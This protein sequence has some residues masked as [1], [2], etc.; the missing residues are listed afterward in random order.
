MTG[1]SLEKC[2]S[3]KTVLVTGHTGFKGS[4]LCIWLHMLGAKV[5][6]ISDR[7]PT[8]PSNFEASNIG[9][10]VEDRRINLIN[11]EELEDAVKEA[12]PDFVFHLA[13]QAL[14]KQSYQDPIETLQTNIMGTANLLESLRKIKNSCVAVM[15]TSD[16]CY[17]NVEW[18]WGYRENDR[19][20]GKD[21]YSASKGGAELVIRTYFESFLKNTPVRL[22]IARAGNVIGGGDWAPD[23]LVPD[24]I[25]AWSE[26]EI[27]EI[28][29]PATTRPWQLVLEPLGGYLC[30]AVSLFKNRELSG[31][32]FN[33]GPI[34]E[35]NFTVDQLITEMQKHWSNVKW[36]NASPDSAK[37]YEA[38]L[39]KLNCDKALHRLNWRPTYNFAETVA[40]TMQWYKAFYQGRDDM[41]DLCK[42]HI[43]EYYDVSLA[44]GIDWAL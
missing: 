22:G 28:K 18:E 24:C 29:N 17:D 32:A 15:I 6:G 9:E 31:E 2:F 26:N 4:W 3:N 7:V 41:Q 44:K 34:A 11:R 19:L 43:R 13:A 36:K 12:K 37:I 16:K 40:A 27:V 1:S 14:V 21:P 10:I 33:F 20:G 39:L 38:S 8:N 23:R 25:R 5:I 42:K 35:N 30:L